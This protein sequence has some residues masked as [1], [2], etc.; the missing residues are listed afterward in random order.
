[1]SFLIRE[2]NKLVYLTCDLLGDVRHGFSTRRGGVSPPPWD[3]LN[4]GVGRGDAMENVREN[5][6]RFC[7]AIGVDVER[8]VLSKQVHEANVR[9]VTAELNWMQKS[10]RTA[11]RLTEHGNL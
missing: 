9:L 10:Q 1:M 3:S 11:Q 4:L 6:R 8:C 5:Y 2:K 7:A